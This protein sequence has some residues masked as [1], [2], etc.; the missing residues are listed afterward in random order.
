ML[1]SAT[2]LDDW[3]PRRGSGAKSTYVLSLMLPRERP[4]HGT[5]QEGKPGARLGGARQ[6]ARH[7]VDA[8]GRRRA[9]AVRRAKGRPRRHPRSAG[10]GH[11]ADRAGRSDED[12]AVRRRRRE[13]LSVHRALRHRDRYRRRRGPNR[14]H[15]RKAPHGAR[16]RQRPGR[17]HRRDQPGAP[18]VFR[19]QGGRQ[20]RLRPRPQRRGAWCWSPAGSSSRTCG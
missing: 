8:G 19:H 4:D 18:D 6:A 17:L 1:S 20:P 3:D 10:D 9:A 5:A 15:V 13:G 7:D 11:P 2:S 16:D 14:P 12:G